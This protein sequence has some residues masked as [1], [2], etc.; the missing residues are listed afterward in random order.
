METPIIIGVA[1]YFLFYFVIVAMI[2]E[3][4]RAEI[5]FMRFLF[6]EPLIRITIAAISV[7]A[8]LIIVRG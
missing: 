5:C 8:Y 2:P 3:N 6:V 7:I 4:E 1:T